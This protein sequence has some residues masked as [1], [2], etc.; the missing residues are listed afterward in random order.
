VTPG[1]EAGGRTTAAA[2]GGALTLAS[3]RTRRRRTAEGGA[4]PRDR[5]FWVS[6]VVPL[7]VFAGLLIAIAVVPGEATRALLAI[8]AIITGLV[9]A[10]LPAFSRGDRSPVD[11]HE[12]KDVLDVMAGSILALRGDVRFTRQEEDAPA[13]AR[14]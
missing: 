12:A 9:G 6:I 1:A 5:T 10:V 8:G 7:V 3:V 14:H 4:A 11:P 13:T 2:R